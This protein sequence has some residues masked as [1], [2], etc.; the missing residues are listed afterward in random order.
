MTNSVAY[1]MNVLYSALDNP[2][3]RS[4]VSNLQSLSLAMSDQGMIEYGIA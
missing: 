2:I 1:H 4:N 3:S